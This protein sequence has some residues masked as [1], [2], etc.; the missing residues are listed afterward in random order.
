VSL[1]RRRALAAALFAAAIRALGAA[2]DPT[3]SPQAPPNGRLLSLSAASLPEA[4]SARPEY[5]GILNEVA[6][7]SI[8]YAS[9]GL[10]VKGYLAVPKTGEH[11]PCVIWNRDGNRAFRAITNRE[12]VSVL[13]ALAKRGY[14]VVASQYRGSPGSD[15]RDEL[16]G[17]DVDDVLNLLPLLESLPRAD[18]SRVGM[19]GWSRGGMMT[20]LALSR[21]TRIAAAVVGSGISDLFD[22]LEKR[23]DM[24]SAFETLI[25]GFHEK[26]EE[27]LAARS[28][29]RWPEKLAP[30]TA[31]LI[32]AGARDWSVSPQQSLDL[33]GALLA[34]HH[35]FRLVVLEGAGHDFREQKEEAD[36]EIAGWLDRY[37]RDREPIP[38]ASTQ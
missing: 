12:A 25:A 26:R 30:Q 2:P 6:V 14:V 34:R 35:P 5:A 22:W 4:A 33:A 7:S 15:G 29:I 24:E 1:A 21:T 20:Y 3:V 17:G 23:R 19:V 10:K 16:G 32:L 18:P 13:G 8:T 27:T 37:V 31:I 36:R 28:A 38:G 11:L 9:D